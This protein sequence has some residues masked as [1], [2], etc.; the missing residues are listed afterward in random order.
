M[1]NYKIHDTRTNNGSQ[2]Q[3]LTESTRKVAGAIFESLDAAGTAK[4]TE[5]GLCESVGC[6]RRIAAAAVAEL[7]AKG[8]IE[9]A[10]A[11]AGTVV[12]WLSNGGGPADRGPSPPRGEDGAT[13]TTGGHHRAGYGA[14]TKPD[15]EP[16]TRAEKFRQELD[17]DGRCTLDQIHAEREA[18]LRAT[19]ALRRQIGPERRYQNL[20][21]LASA[22]ALVTRPDAVRERMRRRAAEPAPAQ[23]GWHPELTDTEIEQNEV[24]LTEMRERFGGDD[25]TKQKKLLRQRLQEARGTETA[26]A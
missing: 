18:T 6:S 5:R 17:G 26:A 8:R 10:R 25:R 16:E 7:E 19:D 12:R 2:A 4:I 1:Q 21:E 11:R 15:Q 9:V 22:I 3:S 20:A 24:I 14:D 13:S 23:R